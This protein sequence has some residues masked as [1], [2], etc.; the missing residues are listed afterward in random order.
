MATKKTSKTKAAKAPKDSSAA[1]SALRDAGKLEE[2]T[3]MARR[4]SAAEQERR[5]QVKG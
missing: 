5:A 2:A 4:L 1:V 3:A